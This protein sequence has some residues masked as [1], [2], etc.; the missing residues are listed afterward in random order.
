MPKLEASNCLTAGD[1]ALVHELREL[2]GSNGE[3]SFSNQTLTKFGLI[4]KKTVVS[5]DQWED[6]DTLQTIM[7]TLLK[8]SDSKSVVLT[9]NKTILGGIFSGMI[10]MVESE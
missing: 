9:Q 1:R 10:I 2:L 8:F 3:E 7:A 5:H 4:L 6:L